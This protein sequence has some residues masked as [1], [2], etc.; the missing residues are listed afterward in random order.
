MQEIVVNS[1]R[2]YNKWIETGIPIHVDYL[3][4][5]ENIAKRLDISI[6]W[7]W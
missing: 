1:D 3:G 6:C 4:S 7:E 5:L 2:T